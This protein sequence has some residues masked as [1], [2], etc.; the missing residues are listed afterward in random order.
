MFETER[1]YI[2]SPATQVMGTVSLMG[3]D[4]ATAGSCYH[5][6]SQGLTDACWKSE[7]GAS[8]RSQKAVRAEPTEGGSP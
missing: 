4:V 6:C 2:R 3:D 5:T 8:G 7:A 1:I